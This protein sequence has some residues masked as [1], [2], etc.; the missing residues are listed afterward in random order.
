M[1]GVGVRWLLVLSALVPAGDLLAEVSA[2]FDRD[3]MHFNETVRL[4][5]QADGAD[6][7]DE[8]DLAPVEAHFRVL[9]QGSSRNVSLVNGRQTSSRT[10]TL[11]LEP[12][13]TGSF[14]L[15]PI[16]VGDE[17][18]LRL[19]INI[20]PEQEQSVGGDVFMEVSLEPG[21]GYVQ[22]QFVLSVRIHFAVPLLDGALGDPEVGN[23]LLRR[24]GEDRNFSVTRE[25]RRYR[26]FERRYAIFPQSSGEL[27]IPPLRFEG[28][29]DDGNR[30]VFGSLVAPGRRIRAASEALEMTVNPP[31]ETDPALPWIPARALQLLDL[32]DPVETVTAGQPV[33]LKVQLQALGLSGEQLP[34]I[35][36]PEVEGLRLYPDQPVR[37][38]RVEGDDVVG[39][40]LQRIAVIPERSGELTIPGISVN[41]WNT[42]TDIRETASLAPRTIRVLPAANAGPETGRQVESSRTSESGVGAESPGDIGNPVVAPAD[43]A[44]AADRPGES[45]WRVIALVSLGIWLVSLV[46]GMAWILRGSR[47]SSPGEKAAT[48]P[49]GREWRKR[50]MRACD[51]NDPVAAK[52]ALR[53][54]VRA[55]GR[56]DGFPDEPATTADA[57]SLAREIERLDAVLYAADGDPKQW[58]G[59]AL[60]HAFDRL[61]AAP[62]VADRESRDPL[63]ELYSGPVEPGRY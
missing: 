2:R 27:A 55:T 50:V 40:Q 11:E 22:Q 12:L 52:Q 59:K 17:E 1:V 15:D 57:A 44:G 43:A 6:G 4:T 25:G 51:S 9:R 34:E 42:Q 10:W 23:A 19:R 3:T 14:S 5:I 31:A 47:R 39:I 20:L 29:V 41:W 54:W 63:D 18:T 53:G 36:L 35:S 56:S 49:P 46:A 60:R 32:S 58:T 24:L 37:E 62:V 7:D 13:A 21:E 28:R 38:T 16:R 26:V 61:A 8:P 45:R 30:G 48:E 33:T